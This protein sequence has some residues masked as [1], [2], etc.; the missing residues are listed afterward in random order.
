MP[1]WWRKPNCGPPTIWMYQTSEGE[2]ERNL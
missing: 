1:L 2:R